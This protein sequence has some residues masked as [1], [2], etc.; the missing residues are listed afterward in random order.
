M[1]ITSPITDRIRAL[2][3][4]TAPYAWGP[5]LSVSRTAILS[6]ITRIKVGQLTIVDVDGQ[7]TVFGQQKLTPSGA[8]RSV[9]S[10][11]QVELRVHKD[12]FWVRLALFADMVCWLW[13]RREGS[14]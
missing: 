3:G 1:G 12:M 11:P 9:Y 2:A 14:D 7:T 4:Y 13:E 10:I 5:L 8:E 6:L